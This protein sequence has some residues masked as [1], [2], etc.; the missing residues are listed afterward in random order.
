MQLLWH[1]ATH[2]LACR[3]PGNTFYISTT[4][5]DG[6]AGTEVSPK[7]TL[8][9]ALAVASNGDR[10]IYLPGSYFFQTPQLITKSVEVT[11]QSGVADGATILEFNVPDSSTQVYLG[12]QADNVDVH[13]LTLRQTG[14]KN[15]IDML[16]VIDRGSDGSI[17][18]GCKPG[19]SSALPAFPPGC[20]RTRY[21]TQRGG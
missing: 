13:G 11:S 1:H 3:A 9:G 19:L 6:N 14:S 8:A 4:G 10:I 12:I 5:S 17:P 20:S 16:V 21:L 15:Q 18:V 2:L 7:A